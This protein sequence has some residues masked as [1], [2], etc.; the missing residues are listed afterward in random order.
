MKVTYTSPQVLENT[1]SV[2][3]GA[4]VKPPAPNSKVQGGAGVKSPAP[5]SKVQEVTLVGWYSQR[6]E[7]PLQPAAARILVGKG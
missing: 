2:Q 5:K 6:V 4:G 1:H 7:L 3:A